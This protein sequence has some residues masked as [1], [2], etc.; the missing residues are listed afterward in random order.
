MVARWI[1]IICRADRI[2]YRQLAGRPNAS[3]FRSA[4]EAQVRDRAGGGKA[5]AASRPS[6]FACPASEDD[7]CRNDAGST[8]SV[9]VAHPCATIALCFLARR[10]GRCSTSCQRAADIGNALGQ[11]VRALLRGTGRTGAAIEFDRSGGNLRLGFEC[12][13]PICGLTVVRRSRCFF[14]EDRMAASGSAFGIWAS[15]QRACTAA[16]VVAR[17][18]VRAASHN[19]RADEFLD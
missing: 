12:R 5:A 13:R 11:L 1:G 3:L 19:A 2:R 18:A 9:D 6:R 17:F 14:A 16:A 15:Y 7:T 10:R 8:N 4:A